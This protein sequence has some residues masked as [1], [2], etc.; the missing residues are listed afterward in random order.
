MQ[1]PYF[2]GY[3]MVINIINYPC[4]VPFYNAENASLK[5]KAGRCDMKFFT[6]RKP[7]L[8]K[9]VIRLRNPSET[10]QT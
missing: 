10:I 9:K 2:E 5:L 1:N 8:K 3:R 6:E 7:T 4:F